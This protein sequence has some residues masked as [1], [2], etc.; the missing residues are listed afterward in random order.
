L[1]S[2]ALHVT[3][4][5]LAIT[6][7]WQ[8]PFRPRPGQ[9]PEVR[10]WVVLPPMDGPRSGRS[11]A[12]ASSARRLAIVSAPVPAPP[13][14]V[15]L[16]APTGLTRAGGPLVVGPQLGDGRAWASPRAALPAAAAEALYGS[17]TTAPDARATRRLYAML[18]SLNQVIDADR[19]AR[20]RPTWGADVAGIPFR[21]DSQFVTIAG[22][23]I[24]TM[25]LAM[26][27]NLLPQG[28]YNEALRARQ[29]EDM[30]QDLLRA[31]L[32]TETFR[33]FQKYVK[34]LRERNQAE[35]DADRARQAPPDTTRVIP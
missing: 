8:A 22:I 15:P 17:D 14:D 19:Q 28:N 33:D 32:R 29:F 23:K 1:T 13:V 27:G 16:R 3:L 5:V 25:A 24:P 10:E 9:Q 21:L 6:V 20:R 11:A 30:R 34:E 35:R 31:A 12:A 2:A 7:A 18:D 4:A 26:L